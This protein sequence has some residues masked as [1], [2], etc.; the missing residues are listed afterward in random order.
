M[1]ESG[2]TITWPWLRRVSRCLMLT[3]ICASFTRSH[4]SNIILG[5]VRRPGVQLPVLCM[6]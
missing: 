4:I 2:A 5:S 6:L 3:S 1:A